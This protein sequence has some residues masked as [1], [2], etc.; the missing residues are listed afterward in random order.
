MA[1]TW[2]MH[3]D[4]GWGWMALMMVFMVLFW[5][6]VI[7]GIVWLVRGSTQGRWTPG[8]PPVSKESALD[9]L[10]RRFAEGAISEEDYRARRA[11]LLGETRRS[12]GAR[13][14]EPVVTPLKQN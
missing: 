8:E 4:F 1:D 14:D 5:G 11:V 6:A 3:G 13:K 12:N 7:F 9:I 2:G 10:E